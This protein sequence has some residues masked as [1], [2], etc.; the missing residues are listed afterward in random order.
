MSAVDRSA[1]KRVRSSVW[2]R[3]RSIFS[4]N[5]NLQP[6][7]RDEILNPGE[8]GGVSPGILHR[9][10]TG[11]QPVISWLKNDRLEAYPTVRIWGLTPLGSPAQLILRV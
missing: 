11:F 10:G 4:F 8:P 2:F 9:R 5:E 3:F 7:R 6:N 1:I